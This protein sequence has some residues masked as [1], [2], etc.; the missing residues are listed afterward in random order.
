MYFADL[1]MIVQQAELA[2]SARRV[3]RKTRTKGGSRTR[4]STL[5]GRVRDWL[6]AVP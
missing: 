4:R 2:R 1:H 3:R 6:W 5:L